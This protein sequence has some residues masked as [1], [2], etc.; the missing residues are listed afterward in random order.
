M[1]VV[2][3]D[4]T[5]SEDEKRKLHIESITDYNDRKRDLELDCSEQTT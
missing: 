2:I 3:D 4:Q 5:L 1:R